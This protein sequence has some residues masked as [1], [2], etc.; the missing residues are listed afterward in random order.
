M[1]LE[2]NLAD[3]CRHA[4][5]FS[6][7]ARFTLTVLDPGDN[8]VVGCVN[9]YPSASEGWDVR[10]QS[11]VRADGSHLDVPLA[12]AVARWLAAEWPWE[13]VDCCGR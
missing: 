6:Q 1:T 7:H 5:D 4:D 10:V 11:W 8:D 9:L 13:R 2:E 12:D 3:L